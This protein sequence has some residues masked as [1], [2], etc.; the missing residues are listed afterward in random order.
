MTTVY[1]FE[2][3]AETF[4]AKE[5][6]T[7]IP[8]KPVPARWQDVITAGDRRR[9]GSRD[10]VLSDERSIGAQGWCEGRIA[11]RYGSALDGL[12]RSCGGTMPRACPPPAL[13]SSGGCGGCVAGFLA[14]E[15]PYGLTFLVSPTIFPT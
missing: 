11:L 15:G 8:G 13:R 3:L 2:K 6:L 9:P 7:V 12:A 14:K 10:P 4:S 5:W 1:G